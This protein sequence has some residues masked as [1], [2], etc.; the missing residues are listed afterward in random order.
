M[1]GAK[2]YK[3]SIAA[4][5][6][7]TKEIYK[8]RNFNIHLKLLDANKNVVPNCKLYLNSGNPIPVSFMLFESAEPYESVTSD[9][10]GRQILKGN[11]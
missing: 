11:P 2:S 9:K 4:I 6:S 3:H 8:E 7:V 5:K 10:K 1:F